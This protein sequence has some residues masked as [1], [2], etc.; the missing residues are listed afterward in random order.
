M[1]IILNVKACSRCVNVRE[2][3]RERERER[4]GER[5][6][7]R[8]RERER[9]RDRMRERE[10]DRM[11]ERVVVPRDKAPLSPQTE[12]RRGY[13]SEQ[14]KTLNFDASVTLNRGG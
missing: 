4:A 12:H 5:E 6:G 8:E 9:G 14:V 3:E 11:R 1:H 10:R 13:R 2:R 7:Q